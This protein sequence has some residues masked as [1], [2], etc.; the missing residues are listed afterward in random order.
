MSSATIATISA[1][2]QNPVFFPHFVRK[3]DALLFNSFFYRLK[4]NALQ[5]QRQGRLRTLAIPGLVT[6]TF[7]S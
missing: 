3:A 7:A 5:D 6:K 1:A 2:R 4:N